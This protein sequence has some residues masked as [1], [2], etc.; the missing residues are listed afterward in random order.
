MLFYVSMVDEHTYKFCWVFFL[1]GG[2]VGHTGQRSELRWGLE[3]R[4]GSHAPTGGS[5][6]P[7]LAAAS[8]LPVGASAQPWLLNSARRAVRA[9]TLD[10]V[11]SRPLRLADSR[12]LGGGALGV[13]PAALLSPSQLFGNTAIQGKAYFYLPV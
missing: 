10:L 11:H 1:P 2:W 12:A 9:D 4:P 13:Q 8:A 6:P 7:S 3:V 5:L